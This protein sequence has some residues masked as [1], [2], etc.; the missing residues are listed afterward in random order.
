MP[1]PPGGFAPTGYGAAGPVQGGY[2]MRPPA[3]LA[4]GS[5][6]NKG[7]WIAIA[8][9]VGVL[10]IALGGLGIYKLATSGAAP[11]ANAGTTVLGTA[12]MAGGSV[13]SE[14]SI[15]PGPNDA[16]GKRTIIVMQKVTNDSSQTIK[17]D[18]YSM[19]VMQKGELLEFSDYPSGKEPDQVDPG[20][21][22]EALRP[23]QETTVAFAYTL[24]D[25]SQVEIE[26]Y[27]Q[28]DLS[29]DYAKYYWQPN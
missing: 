18:E 10:V 7:M 15:L 4:S 8:A 24:V 21:W 23:G 14:F 27:E 6:S 9:V 12:S 1:P 19:F 5:G 20:K 22:W 17:V 26:P 28:N 11:S 29:I 16:N 13:K 3:P 25:S 2:Q